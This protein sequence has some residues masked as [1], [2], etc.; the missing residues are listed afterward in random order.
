MNTRP[1]GARLHPATA[2]FDTGRRVNTQP[3]TGDCVP[4][5]REQRQEI[6]YS[7]PAQVILPCP[8]V[9]RSV[10]Y[11]DKKRNATIN[12]LCVSG[13]NIRSSTRSHYSN[14]QPVFDIHSFHSQHEK[15]RS[16]GGQRWREKRYEI[17]RLGVFPYRKRAT[18]SERV[19]TLF[20]DRVLKYLFRVAVGSLDTVERHID[21]P[22]SLLN[23]HES[24]EWTY[25]WKKQKFVNWDKSLNKPLYP[26]THRKRKI[27]QI[28][29][30]SPDAKRT[31][32]GIRVPSMIFT[33]M[34]TYVCIEIHE[35]KIQ[36]VRS[37]RVALIFPGRFGAVVS[38]Q[39]TGYRWSG[40]FEWRRPVSICRSGY[41]VG[42]KWRA[43]SRGSDRLSPAICNFLPI[44]LSRPDVRV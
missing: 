29:E 36:L 31:N 18:L 25:K 2:W 16:F 6:S 1:W 40:R 7:L 35:R 3:M 10:L 33:C 13:K 44:L 21:A 17:T 43:H 11:R 12:I 38:W 20:R 15:D 4:W 14:L 22:I 26:E 30:E 8:F 19:G 9:L 23:F 27:R 39:S 37:L 24:V 41:F 32:A 42:S 28:I 34:Y 5:K